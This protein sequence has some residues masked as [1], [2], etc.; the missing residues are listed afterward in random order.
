MTRVIFFIAFLIFL[1]GTVFAQTEMAAVP[2]VPVANPYQAQGVKVDI[3]AENAVK[4]REQA[5]GAALGLA[6]RQVCTQVTQDSAGCDKATLP[7]TAVLGRA[8]KDFATTQEQMGATRYTATYDMRFRPGSMRHLLAGLSMTPAPQTENAN[9]AFPSSQ[10]QT[11]APEPAHQAMASQVPQASVAAPSSAVHS[12]LILPF[13]Q[14]GG[15]LVLWSGDNPLRDA[16]SQMDFENTGLR[17]PLGE[18]DDMQMI[19]EGRGL[20]LTS[21]DLAPLLKKYEADQAL[22]VLT[23]LGENADKGATLMLYR[24]APTQ[25]ARP[26]Y[27]DSVALTGAAGS[28]VTVDGQTLYGGLSARLRDRAQIILSRLSTA[29]TSVVQVDALPAKANAQEK[30]MV[31]ATEKGSVNVR[32]TYTNMQDW[33]K[34]KSRLQASPGIDR[35]QVRRLTT[36]EA[37]VKIDFTGGETTL[38][39]QLQSRGIQVRGRSGPTSAAG[40]PTPASAAVLDSAPAAGWQMNKVEPAAGDTGADVIRYDLQLMPWQ[41]Y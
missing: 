30:E 24:P 1:P 15:K 3:R 18:L 37:T 19:D 9:S 31:P 34:I 41:G 2:A 17:L 11:S 35:L 21:T 32:I 8:L 36:T 10:T 14:K 23:V 33:A 29:P 7:D 39:Q 38:L 12:A 5:F 26:E 16:L 28:T 27:I 22:L 25:A 40:W 13:F 20:S 6:F 4:A